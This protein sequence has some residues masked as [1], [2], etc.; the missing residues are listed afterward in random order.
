M[1][2]A[3]QCLAPL[4]RLSLSAAAR[5]SAASIPRFLLP[6]VPVASQARY[7][8]GGAGAFKKREK[9]KRVH[10]TFRSH[11]LSQLDKFSLCDTLR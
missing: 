7:A 2:S 8:A 3:T 9:K 5:P 1:A 6:A 11:D 4:A 10:K